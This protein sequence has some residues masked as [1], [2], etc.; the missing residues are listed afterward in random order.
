MTEK[1]Y[2]ERVEKMMN[3]K[4]YIEQNRPGLFSIRYSEDFMKD[5]KESRKK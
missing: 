1:E 3:N 5:F 2:Q 4:K